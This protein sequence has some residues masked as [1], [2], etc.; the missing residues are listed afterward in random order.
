MFPC[1][2]HTFGVAEAIELGRILEQLP[3]YLIVY[4]IEGK[5]FNTGCDLSTEVAQAVPH[6]VQRVQQDIRVIQARMDGR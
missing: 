5:Q 2:T 6:V 1:S 3:P 4:G